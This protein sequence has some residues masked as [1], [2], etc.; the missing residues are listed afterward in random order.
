MDRRISASPID[1]NAALRRADAMA[2]AKR[3]R[4]GSERS[5]PRFATA[6]QAT[7]SIDF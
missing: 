5:D 4:R 6:L 3:L 7:S 1:P 2:S